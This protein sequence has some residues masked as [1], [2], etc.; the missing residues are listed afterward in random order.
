MRRRTIGE[1]L[2]YRVDLIYGEGNHSYLQ[3]GFI[4][5]GIFHTTIKEGNISSICIKTTPHFTT[6]PRS[7]QFVLSF[8]N[9]SF[10]K[11]RK[12]RD[13]VIMMSKRRSSRITFSQ[14]LRH[15]ASELLRA[16][17]MIVGIE[18]RKR[19]DIVIM[20]SKRRSSGITSNI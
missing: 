6:L 12:G 14:R 7:F 4:E 10:I 18:E 15:Y 16:M 20:M 3:N 2:D 8:I 17:S 1:Q 5:K 11:E 13:R 19:R 9:G